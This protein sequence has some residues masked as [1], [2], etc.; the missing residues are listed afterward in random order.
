MAQGYAGRWCCGT[1]SRPML[2]VPPAVLAAPGSVCPTLPAS[3]PLPLVCQTAA[4]APRRSQVSEHPFQ[5]RS[6]CPWHGEAGG[7]GPGWTRSP[8]PRSLHGGHRD[9][10]RCHVREWAWGGV[11]MPGLLCT[12]VRVCMHALWVSPDHSHGFL[13]CGPVLLASGENICA[14]HLPQTDLNDR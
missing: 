7:R 9:F 6:C 11:G 13:V 10:A 5:G 2:S 3:A 8:C 4:P 12:P 14:S 1:G